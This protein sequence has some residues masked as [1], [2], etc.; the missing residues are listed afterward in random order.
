M[1]G[2]SARASHM[3]AGAADAHHG[4]GT[5]I[6]GGLFIGLESIA[7]LFKCLLANWLDHVG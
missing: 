7:G 6:A 4:E 2:H 5:I 1:H 3:R